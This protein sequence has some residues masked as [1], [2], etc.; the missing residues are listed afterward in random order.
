[1]RATT[2]APPIAR[3]TAVPTTVAYWPGNVAR[4]QSRM[5]RMK[6]VDRITAI[7]TA[8]ATVKRAITRRL[9]HS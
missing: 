4:I 8:T 9:Y 6:G 5:S 7:D 3:A 2:R 1:M